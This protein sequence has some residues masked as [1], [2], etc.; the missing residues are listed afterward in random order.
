MPGPL[1]S[2]DGMNGLGDALQD[3][4]GIIVHLVFSCQ[5]KALM[6]I[7]FIDGR[8][9]TLISSKTQTSSTP[10]EAR[11]SSR[12]LNRG[13]LSCGSRRVRKTLSS[14]QSD[15]L[16]FLL[17]PKHRLVV[18]SYGSEDQKLGSTSISIGRVSARFSYMRYYHHPVPRQLQIRLDRV[19]PR[20]DGTSEGAQRVLRIELLEAAMGD[21]LG[22][23]LAG[24]G[25]VLT[26]DL[27]IVLIIIP[28]WSYCINCRK[29]SRLISRCEVLFRGGGGAKCDLT[30]LGQSERGF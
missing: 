9:L 8:I 11:Y 14:S 15:S 7:S 17:T 20:L 13:I 6:P 3:G 12:S 18:A 22:K 30:F 10:G 24:F 1:Q 19:T 28:C 29:E 21:R 26:Q 2:W 4:P 5:Y 23:L 25:I 27:I 16:I